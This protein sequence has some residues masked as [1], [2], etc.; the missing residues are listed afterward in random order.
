VPRPPCPPFNPR[1]SHPFLAGEGSSCA[2]AP[3]A[4]K[5][6]LHWQKAQTNESERERKENNK[7]THA[8]PPPCLSLPVRHPPY[9]PI[10]SLFPLAFHIFF[11][12]KRARGESAIMISRCDLETWGAGNVTAN[13]K[14]AS[15]TSIVS[16]NSI[17][18]HRRIIVHDLFACRSCATKR[19]RSTNNVN[20]RRQLTALLAVL[21]GVNVH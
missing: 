20:R 1:A 11:Q 5:T 16:G 10:V 3:V 12:T 14:R 8:S 19:A 13:C 7:Q 4:G 21:F 9:S 17:I 2:P 6:K 18:R 15:F